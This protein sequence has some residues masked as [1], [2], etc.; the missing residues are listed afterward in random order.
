[1]K[2]ITGST[3]NPKG[4]TEMRS[5]DN[6]PDTSDKD[7][8]TE[9][10][11]IEK[12]QT[13][14]YLIKQVIYDSPEIYWKYARTNLLFPTIIIRQPQKFEEQ[15]NLFREKGLL[16]TGA[17]RTR[18]PEGEYNLAVDLA[19]SELLSIR[20]QL[21]IDKMFMSEPLPDLASTI[22]G[23]PDISLETT[24]QWEEPFL[25]TLDLLI[26]KNSSLASML[27]KKAKESLMGKSDS[28]SKAVVKAEIRAEFKKAIR[29]FAK[30]R[31]RLLSEQ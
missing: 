1:M 11:Q 16:L 22:I 7:E 19:Y 4:Y 17:G 27:E 3:Y 29:R 14:S 20:F 10:E 24:D 21:I 12:L 25:Q 18:D 6:H 13:A 30:E 8:F 2:L 9:E 28:P 26:E 15:I 31:D 23:L 5:N